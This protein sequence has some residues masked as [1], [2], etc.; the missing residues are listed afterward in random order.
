MGIGEQLQG[1]LT[2]G[3]YEEKT[4]L[5]EFGA[6]TISTNFMIFSQNHKMYWF[7]IGENRN[8]PDMLS[9]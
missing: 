3:K 9:F 7:G 8:L 2:I 5:I 1:P 6:L 4:C